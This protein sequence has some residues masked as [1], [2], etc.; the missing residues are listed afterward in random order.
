MT[1]TTTPAHRPL[2]VPDSPIGALADD[3]LG[4]KDVATLL[5][6]VLADWLPRAEP[7][8]IALY[9]PWGAGKSGV[10]SLL[11]NEISESDALKESVLLLSFSL[12]K[13]GA[14]NVR[15]GLLLF[16][17]GPDGLRTGVGIAERLSQTS[18]RTEARTTIN[19]SKFL[20]W[21]AGSVILLLVYL[22]LPPVTPESAFL[23]RAIERILPLATV[24]PVVL[25]ALLS[26][27][28]LSLQTHVSEGSTTPPPDRADQFKAEFENLLSKARAMH[29]SARGRQWKQPQKLVLVFDDLDRVPPALAWDVLTTV[30]TFMDAEHCV[31]IV[32]CDRDAV[33][34]AMKAQ[35]G[36]Q[37]EARAIDFLDKFFQVSFNLP[38]TF[39]REFREI[40][41]QVC[42]QLQL[43]TDVGVIAVAG[44]SRTPRALKV[45]LN[46]VSLLTEFIDVRTARI[47]SLHVDRFHA[48]VAK[49]HAIKMLWP[50][51][52]RAVAAMPAL[53]A[54]LEQRAQGIE[55]QE[56]SDVSDRASDLLNPDSD[57]FCRGLREFLV[58][59]LGTPVG[60]DAQAAIKLSEAIWAEAQGDLGSLQT[61]FATGTFEE[62]QRLFEKGG[63]ADAVGYA[64]DAFKDEVQT[65]TPEAL[66]GW[67][68]TLLQAFF[69][70]KAERISEEVVGLAVEWV[71]SP[72]VSP[73]VQKLPPE[74]LVR[75]V[76]S[77]SDAR[78]QTTGIKLVELAHLERANPLPDYTAAVLRALAS[79]RERLKSLHP[80]L[81]SKIREALANL[82]TVDRTQALLRIS[83]L[84]RDVGGSDWDFWWDERL[85][86]RLIESISAGTNA[87]EDGEI[88]SF[89][90]RA[91][92]EPSITE[93]SA[94]VKVATLLFAQ[95]SGSE[96]DPFRE[97]GLELIHRIALVGTPTDLLNVAEA[98]SCAS[99]V[100]KQGD[101]DKKLTVLIPIIRLASSSSEEV[102]KIV[103]AS[104]LL[105]AMPTMSAQHV[106]QLLGELVGVG[107]AT[108]EDWSLS[109]L[110]RCVQLQ[111]AMLFSTVSE[112]SRNSKAIADGLDSAFQADQS[113]G[114]QLVARVQPHCEGPI[115][116][117]A[118]TKRIATA[119]PD[120]GNT[121]KLVT[122]L[123]SLSQKPDLQDAVWHAV[124]ARIEQGVLDSDAGAAQLLR[125]AVDGKLLARLPETDQKHLADSASAVVGQAQAQP[126]DPSETIA[127]RVEAALVF[128]PVC[129]DAHATAIANGA[130][131]V[132]AWPQLTPTVVNQIVA[133]LTA[134]AR[135]LP[136]VSDDALNAIKLTM[137]SKTDERRP[138]LESLIQAVPARP[139]P[140]PQSKPVARG[141]QKHDS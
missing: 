10:I 76:A 96:P 58:A 114:D 19:W 63:V 123:S 125:R 68:A 41:D 8:H 80:D 48:K 44:F 107:L 97:R 83:I 141:R 31:Y 122:M 77:T 49:V 7:L 92:Y 22:V 42:K 72:Q 50:E 60:Q 113:F 115:F 132:L 105:N 3:A 120:V 117:E 129:D 40:S 30:K 12:W 57:E 53:M 136:L 26:N 86:T 46:Q 25:G 70:K 61:S 109:L 121:T 106:T 11:K 93:R 47:G 84:S 64:R 128:E 79:E 124:A 67:T 37:L 108:R 13:F 54:M 45:F 78:A 102:K 24:I 5:A 32:P 51:C 99:L 134:H 55:S 94:S 1:K 52:G 87:A 137:E 2:L 18:A 112:K 111:D 98:E 38:E 82:V 56:K 133:A 35:S 116:A 59:T 73:H 36:P 139:A 71:S 16:L 126:N 101:A 65:A 14:E 85:G 135:L 21:A 15:R 4:H 75:V 130:A 127:A 131:H 9:G 100:G 81:G 74:P 29:A 27:A 118:I 66:V 88:I 23:L 91:G 89:V 6:R 95:S 138:F 28:N 69:G 110:T 103:L 34:E 90:S 119:G 62:V 39:P 140:L 104:G 43:P 20:K 33:V 17:D